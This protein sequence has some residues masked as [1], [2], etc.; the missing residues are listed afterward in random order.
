[1]TD[2]VRR[3]CWRL[4]VLVG[5][6]VP[7]LVFGPAPAAQ[8]HT[9][10]VRTVPAQ[11]E[12]LDSP[13]QEVSLEF[14]EPFATVGARLTLEVDGH[15]ESLV[16]QGTQGGRVLRADLDSRRHGVYVVAW[17]VVAE[18]GHQSA[19][20]FAFGV[21]AGT[22]DIPT[23]RKA[24]P[25][26]EPLRVVMG[27][28]FFVGLALAA[29]SLATD[30]ARAAPFR[31]NSYRSGLVVAEVAALV[32]WADALVSDEPVRQRVLLATT[33][34]GLAVALALGRLTRRWPTALALGVAASAWSARGHGAVANGVVGWVL[35]EIHLVA[36]A[37]WVGALV[38][39]AVELRREG[40]DADKLSIARRYARLAAVL[41]VIL[42]AAGVGSAFLLI[43][44]LSDSWQTG[45][46]QTL[47]VKAGLLVVALALAAAGRH[48][49][50]RHRIAR[51][52]W[53]TPVE[54]LAL[55]GVLA[56]AAVLTKIAP[57]RSATPVAGASLLGPP[58]IAGPV[59]RDAGLAGN[60]TVS[61]TAGADQLRVEVFVPGG[62]PATDAHVEVDGELPDGAGITLVPRP[63]G[64]GCVTQRLALPDGTTRLDV[65]AHTKDWPEGTFRAELDSPPAASDPAALTDLVARIRAV[66][67]V[68][69]VEATTSG[70]GSV[71]TPQT[72]QLSGP[73]LVDL[74]PWAAGTADDIHP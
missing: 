2:R 1:M 40:P 32:A 6:A 25:T 47:L 17:E 38:S 27:W 68:S 73:D 66:P 69:F 24:S 39:L 18:D 12:R 49:L 50:S 58:P 34:A 67:A 74:E 41:V 28:V 60:L 20:E 13:R 5:V 10:L 71:V 33:A 52:R 54:A 63:C 9:F 62:Q 65:T 43:D 29:G 23:A 55:V 31:L 70:P 56:A 36:G 57:P 59:V 35:D 7:L 46:G 4:V 45:Y 64:P 48:A 19:G 37:V 53:T 11:G 30:C 44:R 3:H 42:A 72:F 22:G 16:A 8:A 21:G 15:T 51:L 26:P 61:V 14:T